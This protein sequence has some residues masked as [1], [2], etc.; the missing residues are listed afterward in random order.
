MSSPEPRITR[1]R[2]LKATLSLVAV[3]TAGGAVLAAQKTTPVGSLPKLSVLD[4]AEYTVLCAIAARLCPAGDDA[5]GAL[6][7]RVPEAI[8]VALAHSDAESQKAIKGALALFENALGGALAG[9]RV[10]PFTQLPPERQDRVLAAWQHSKLGVRR[11]IYRALS[12][13]V[14]AFYWG[15]ARTW[16]R[17]GYGGPPDV[18]ALRASYADNLVDLDALRATPVA[19]GT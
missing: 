4:A 8:D 5:P 15:N 16:P 13:S 10:V 6:A 3:A 17:I 7:L 12:A 18:A 2:L 1:R 11:T 19:K 9:E 14:M